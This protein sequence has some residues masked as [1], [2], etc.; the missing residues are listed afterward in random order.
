MSTLMQASH[1]WATRPSD[2]R[3]TS[4]TDMQTH[5]NQ[6]RNECKAV[7]VPSR[8]AP[9]RWAE[10]LAP[11][12]TSYANSS[13]HSVVQAIENAKAARLEKVD[14]FL[15]K[16]FSRRLAGVFQDVHKLEEG[17]PIETLWDAATAATAYARTVTWQDQRVEIER[18]AGE[19]ID[20]AG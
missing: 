13:T 7:V 17:R 16:R 5:F 2:E 8:R 9:E 6:I 14:E 11:A 18:Q 15:A 12:L 19:L 4:L 3:F 1:Q 20:L 10:E